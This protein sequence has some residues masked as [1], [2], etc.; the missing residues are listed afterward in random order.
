MNQ[1]CPDK[2]LWELELEENIIREG[3][4]LGAGV[5]QALIITERLNEIHTE[6]EYILASMNSTR[7]CGDSTKD[8]QR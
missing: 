7:S 6:R 2:R 5:L 8:A 3:Y 4:M 1:F